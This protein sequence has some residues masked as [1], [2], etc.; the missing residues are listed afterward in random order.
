LA[1]IF[2]QIMFQVDQ[3]VEILDDGGIVAFPTDTVYGLG[4]DVFN[5]EAVE[6]I[7]QVKRRP[8]DMALPVLLSDENE[9]EYVVSDVP[10]IARVLIKR[11]WPGGL[12]LVMPKRD[13]LPDI[14]TAGRDNVAVRVPDHVVP[15]SL[16]RGLGK[17]IVGTSA[18]ISSRSSLLT[19]AEVHKELGE[20]VDFIIDSGKCRGGLE[21]TVVD[22]TGGTPVI[23][24]RGII[25]EDEIYEACGNISGGK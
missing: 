20:Q 22:V 21:S 3:A 15:L 17:P 18:N 16:I 11:F 8:R 5:T 4:S 7:Y 19:A 14:I 2:N 6:R 24:R 10:E 13:S 23:L 12:T 1:K 9:L 25:P